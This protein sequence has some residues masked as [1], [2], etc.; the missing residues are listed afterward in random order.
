MSARDRRRAR[1]GR[2]GPGERGTGLRSVAGQVF[3]LEALIA[4][5]V[6]AAAVFVTF[7]QARNDT[8]RDAR[9]R[10][11]AVAEAFAKAPGIDDALT[12]ADPTAELQDRA[13]ATRR[14]TGVDFIAVLS[15]AGLRYTDSEPELIGLKA[16]GD[17]TR[18]VVDGESFTEL[19]RGRPTTPYG[20]WSPWWTTGAGSSAWS[21]A[22]SRWRASRRL[23]RAGCRCSRARRGARWSSPWAGPPW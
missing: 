18:A 16:T 19:F 9:V 4:L 12:S 21:P 11:L 15:P 14:A 17:L 3:A 23:W 20:P 10:S 8:E 1:G 22:A 7:Y 6:I 2:P 5:L 13:E